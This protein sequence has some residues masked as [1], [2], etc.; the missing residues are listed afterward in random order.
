[1][2]NKLENIAIFGAT[3]SIGTS[4]LAILAEHKDKYSVYALSAYSRLDELLQLCQKFQPK[5]VAVA[6][7]DVDNFAQRLTQANLN[8]DVVGGQDGLIDI[9]TDSQVDTVVASIVGSAGLPSTLAGVQAGKRILL[10][11]KEALVM[12]G[13][14]MMQTARKSQAVILPVDSEHNAMFQCLPQAVQIDNQQI[15]QQKH[16]IRQLWLTASGGTFLHS[17]FAEMQ[18][19]TVEQAVKHPNWSMGQKISVDS[20]TMMNK[21]LELI[22][23]CYLFNL[24]EDKI[25]VAIHPQ[26]II[27]SMVEYIDGSILA[28]MGTPDMKTPIAHCLAYPERITSGVQRLDLFKMNKLEFI[29]PDLDKFGCL[30]LARQAMIETQKGKGNWANISLNASNE[31]AVQAFLQ[32]QI[33]LTDIADINRQ[34]LEKMSNHSANPSDLTEIMEIDKVA[35]NIALSNVK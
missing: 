25:T 21:G 28:Q 4:T 35:R 19:A 27:H 24:T 8:I 26:S 15:H 16:G 14:L 18:S 1:M 5:R 30:Q 29:E 31:V 12:A 9:A 34:V 7:K 10:A 20:S 6:E 33:R 17:S 13:D 22:E 2:Q 3:G 11:N 32:R 23:A